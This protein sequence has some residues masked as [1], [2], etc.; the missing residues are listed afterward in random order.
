MNFLQK[1]NIRIF[2]IQN[3]PLEKY[4]YERVNWYFLFMY[5]DFSRVCVILKSDEETEGGG[6]PRT[7][8]V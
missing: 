4:M 2:L 8:D 1:V 6:G 3:S 5:F 7:L